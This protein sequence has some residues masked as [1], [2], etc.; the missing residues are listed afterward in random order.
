[1]YI[2]ERTGYVCRDKDDYL[3]IEERIR[4]ESSKYDRIRNYFGTFDDYIRVK[5]NVVIIFNSSSRFEYCNL[6]WLLDDTHYRN[7]N[8]IEVSALRC[9]IDISTLEALLQEG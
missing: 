3:W 2:V 8:Y 6:E 7:Y 9:K 1:M 4:E 5:G